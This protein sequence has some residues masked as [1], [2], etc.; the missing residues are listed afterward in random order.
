M[1]QDATSSTY[2][3]PSRDIPA[4]Q[5]VISQKAHARDPAWESTRIFSV[6]ESFF[7]VASIPLFYS[8]F[9]TTST[10]STS[11]SACAIDLLSASRETLLQLELF[12]EDSILQERPA[13]NSTGVISVTQG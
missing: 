1:S 7:P 2:H 12:P 9:L 8:L 13:S 5:T 3:A 6:S 11:G 10:N 4:K